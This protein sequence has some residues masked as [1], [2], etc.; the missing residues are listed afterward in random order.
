MIGSALSSAFV[1]VLDDGVR[2]VRGIDDAIYTQRHDAAAGS[3][4]GGH[5]RHVLDHYLRLLD[6]IG[7]GRV[8]YDA[9]ERDL[10]I[11]QDRE[12]AVAA[13]ERL[14]A[15]CAM[16]AELDPAF[17][18]PVACSVSSDGPAPTVVSSL[19]REMVF[20]ISHAV[21]HYAIMAMMGRHL[22]AEVPERFGYAPSTVK[23]L[24]ETA[25]RS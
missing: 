22:G 23:H 5:F 25:S 11:E 2:F 10:R 4:V 21:H 1:S 20:V 24:A 13:A 6:G 14:L 3:S 12:V 16:L 19:G 18:L 7:C 8:D 15:G 17:P 9:R